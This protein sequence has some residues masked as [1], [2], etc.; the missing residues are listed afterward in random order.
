MATLEKQEKCG[1]KGK[2]STRTNGSRL[3]LKVCGGQATFKAVLTLH[4]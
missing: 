3:C 1:S 2:L 4:P